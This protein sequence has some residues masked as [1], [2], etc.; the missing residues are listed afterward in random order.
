[1]TGIK[2]YGSSGAHTV[3]GNAAGSR[4]AH[5]TKQREEQQK[6]YEAKV[7]NIEKTNRRGTLIDA[8]FQSHQDDDESE[9]KRQTV[10]LVTAE[11][12]RKKRE[13]LQNRKSS[14]VD[15]D[16][17]RFGEQ[18]KEAKKKKRRKTKVMGPLSFDLDDDK[19]E[20]DTSVTPKRVK[21]SIKNPNVETDFLPDK[22]REKEEARER[23]KLRAEWEEEQERI[24]NES[25]AVTYSYW[26]GSGH[27]REIT[28]P[29][30]TTI[31]KYLEL[32]KQQLVP[33]FAELRSVSAEKLI[34]VKEDLII[35]HHYSF[36][37]LIVTKARGK[38]GPL[39]HFDVHDDVRL[40]QDRRIQK[41]ESHPGKVVDRY[42]Y[43]KNKHIFPAS[44]W[45]VY[46]PSVVREKY[47]IHGD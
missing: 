42:W 43:E 19:D 40:V 2:R 9:F 17:V 8:N 10:G 46:D 24:R 11:E 27:R 44:R 15:N 35:P 31:G 41:D 22:E 36:Y 4:A 3:E 38:S 5:L 16:D 29:K 45:E 21:K 12:F 25:V 47:T 39:F 28:V 1:M 14:N 33:E 34:Y 37:D 26:D 6:E 30:K 13:D 20:H 23:E 32:V 7:Q 18:Q